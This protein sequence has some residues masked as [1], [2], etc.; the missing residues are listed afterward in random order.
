MPQFGGKRHWPRHAAFLCP[1]T[2]IRVGPPA[3]VCQIVEVWAMVH[4][5]CKDRNIPIPVVE[6]PEPV[7]RVRVRDNR[8]RAHEVQAA[9]AARRLHQGLLYRDAYA[10]HHFNNAG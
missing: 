5:L 2:K 9:R 4:N 3:K 6:D 7:A 8:A 1:K 10:R